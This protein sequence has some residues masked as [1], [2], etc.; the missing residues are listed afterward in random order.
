MA[1]S[2]VSDPQLATALGACRLALRRIARTTLDPAIDQRMLELGE[3][4]EFLNTGEHAE[5]MA[6]VNFAQN[7]T[8]EKLEAEAALQ[9]LDA[10]YP[11]A[12]SPQ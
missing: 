8:L 4:K 1:T 12:A 2:T 7:R 9:R 6:L 11:E 5:L 3:R 10:A